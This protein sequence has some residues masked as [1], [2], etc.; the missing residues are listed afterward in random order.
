MSRL[1]FP[2]SLVPVP[3]PTLPG[4]PFPSRV[5]IQLHA[6]W[7]FWV[8]LCAF[9]SYASCLCILTIPILVFLQ[10]PV[11]SV[12]HHHHP[13]PVSPVT[14][15][16]SRILGLVV[17]RWHLSLLSVCPSVCV[18]VCICI[19]PP[20]SGQWRC[21]CNSSVCLRL[22]WLCSCCFPL[23]SSRVPSL[24]RLSSCV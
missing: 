21:D 13:H 16:R 14:A 24:L 12:P 6:P 1:P 19:C 20:S 18:F 8:S 5:L 15:A 17:G 7:A 23:E 10:R 11:C 22:L 4:F 9:A 3:V 2:F